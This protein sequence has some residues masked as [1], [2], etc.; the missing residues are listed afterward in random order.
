MIDPARNVP[1][2]DMGTGSRE[3]AWIETSTES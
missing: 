1:A 2:P 3:M